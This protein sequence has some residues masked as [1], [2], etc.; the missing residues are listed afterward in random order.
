ML[1]ERAEALLAAVNALCERD[2]YRLLDE[3]ELL[4]QSRVSADRGELSAA[5]S[6]L[7]EGRYIDVCYAEDGVYC[8]RVL[9]AGRAYAAQSLTDGLGAARRARRS[10]LM[11]FMGGLCGALLGALAAFGAMLLAR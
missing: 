6:L 1:N 10:A 8:L 4:A 11:C 7:Q 5:L 3:E 2:A 9:P